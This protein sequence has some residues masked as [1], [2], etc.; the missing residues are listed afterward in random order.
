MSEESLLL[1]LPVTH[2]IYAT[3]S[4]VVISAML[5]S[6]SVDFLMMNS[7]QAD[8]SMMNSSQADFSSTPDYRTCALTRDVV[9]KLTPGKSEHWLTL[10]AAKLCYGSIKF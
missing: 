3:P 7:F 2:Q 5:Y 10:P 1:P 8:F 6:S 4:R 9:A